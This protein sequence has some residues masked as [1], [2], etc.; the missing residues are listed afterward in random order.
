M[1]DDQPFDESSPRPDINHLIEA[2]LR[3]VT[4]RGFI[5]R[6][7]EETRPEFER[8]VAGWL[9]SGE[10]IACRPSPTA[11]TTPSSAFLGMLRAAT[12]ARRSCASTPHG[13]CD[14]AATR[15][16]HH[17]SVWV[18]RWQVRSVGRPFNRLEA[19]ALSPHLPGPH[20]LADSIA[21][22]L[23]DDNRVGIAPR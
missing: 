15:S 22:F 19:A 14:R 5:V 6:D 20:I 13:R 7:H 2:V 23:E 16:S 21:V 18:L 11:S 9:R 4:L 8:T 10:V 17:P 3:R 1:R 12:S